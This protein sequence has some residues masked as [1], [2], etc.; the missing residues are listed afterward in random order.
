MPVSKQ[1]KRKKSRTRIKS[2]GLSG[3]AIIFLS[4]FIVVFVVSMLI[5]ESGKEAVIRRL[6]EGE[7]FRK[8][9]ASLN[10]R[11]GKVVKKVASQPFSGPIVIEIDN[12]EVT[13]G[14]Q[15]AQKIWVEL[16]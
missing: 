16:L 3:W 14:M 11:V 12:T 13:L 15:M 9:L 2:P 1:S 4:V 10:I 6:A 5:P 8:R 7:S